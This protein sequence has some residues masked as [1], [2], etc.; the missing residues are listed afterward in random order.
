MASEI[1]VDKINSLSGVGTVTL[2]PTGVDIAGITTAATLRA[3]TG[4]V[5]SLT[6]GSLTSLGA[7]SGTTGTFSGGL[8]I[9]SNVDI[10]DSIRHKDD[11]DTIIR[12]PSADTVTVETAGSER[13]R[14]DSDGKIGI[15]TAS[16]ATDVHTLSSSDHII[17]HQS[18]TA[19][20]DVRL[21]FRDNGSVDQ[22]GIHYAFNGNSM[23]FRT[24][25]GER[26]RIDSSGNVNIGSNTSA[27]PFTY[28]RFG[29]SQYGAADIRPTNEASHKVGLSFYVDGTQDTTINP[30]EALRIASDGTIHVNSSDSASGGRIYATGSALYLQSGNGRQTLKVSDA[31]AGVNRTIEMTSAGNLSFPNG[32]GIDFSATGDGSGTMTNELLDDYE[33]GTWNILVTPGGGSY[34]VSHMNARYVRIGNIVTVQG[35]W[36]AASISGVSGSLTVSGLPYAA[37]DYSSGGGVRQ[38]LN[39]HVAHVNYS[40]LTFVKLRVGN[41]SS[42]GSIMGNTAGA[43]GGSQTWTAGN[44]ALSTELYISGSY[45]TG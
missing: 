21:N 7:V 32:N 33:E 4:I 44:I 19:G 16:P 8:D 31:A 30:T 20:A 24:A 10:T 29:A 3:T 17:T 36:R 41:N 6:A 13:V 23:R 26:L 14:I 38:N 27:N 25:Q 28:L 35:W 45:I 37:L 39:L 40:N 18:G 12:F 11:T 2:S 34:G 9:T 22:G 5:T 42:Q 1:R 15:G 43:S